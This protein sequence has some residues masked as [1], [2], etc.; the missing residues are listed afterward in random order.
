[1]NDYNELLFFDNEQGLRYITT[2]DV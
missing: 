1:M 2:A